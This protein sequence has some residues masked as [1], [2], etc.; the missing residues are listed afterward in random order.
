MLRLIRF[1]MPILAVFTGVIL[2]ISACGTRV[3]ELRP[4]FEPTTTF[5]FT[6]R[7]IAQGDTNVAV[8]VQPTNTRI[9]PT[10]T[11][12]PASATPTLAPTVEPTVEPTEAV[13]TDAAG[14]PEDGAVL[15]EVVVGSSGHTC[16]T[17]HNPDEPVPG[18][19]P[20]LYGIATVAD[21]RIDGLSAEEYLYQSI[22]DPRTFVAPPQGD[23]DEWP[24]NLMPEDW[25]VY[26]GD[27]GVQDV[28]A[29]LLT[30]DQ[31]R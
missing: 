16:K 22:T 14:N 13:E 3:T 8:V 25:L 24:N 15:F 27:E 12:I 30:L 6:A 9:P 21:T 29:Y 17:C 19:G 28:I 2:I 31:A 1:R 18:L 11:P 5:D 20:Y 26:L 23:L 7:Q 4:T 10:A